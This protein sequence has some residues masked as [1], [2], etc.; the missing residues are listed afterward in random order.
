MDPPGL[1]RF[2]KLIQRLQLRTLIHEDPAADPPRQRLRRLVLHESSGRYG[3]DV[4]KFLKGMLLGF[5]HE[6]E[7]HD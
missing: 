6:E 2:V 7:D 4:V 1:N 3:E 5:G